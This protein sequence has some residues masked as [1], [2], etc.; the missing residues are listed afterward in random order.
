MNA[1]TK[2]RITA[3]ACIG[4]SLGF[5]VCLGCS[6]FIDF[7][8]NPVLVESDPGPWACLGQAQAPEP[9][10]IESATVQVN[11]CSFVSNCTEAVVGLTAKVCNKRDVGCFDPIAEDIV[12]D[13]GLITVTVPTGN[14]GFDGYLQINSG[15][16][17]CTDESAFGPVGNSLC[18]MVP[19]CDPANPNESCQVPLFAPALLFMNPAITADLPEPLTLPLF[20]L[21]ALA[22]IVG[23][24]GV[25]LDPT[26][27]AVFITAVDCD[28]NPASGVTYS[29]DQSGGSVQQLYV[30]QGVVSDASQTDSSGIGGFV[31]VPPGFTVVKASN[32]EGERIGEIGLQAAPLTLSYSAIV[33]NN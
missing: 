25:Q 10:S 7:P 9:P 24:A 12:D 29:I 13:N 3:R 32:A 15:T 17:L 27:G 19:A 30:D 6:E 14:T 4:A 23:A 22:A 2:R 31:G 16:A 26:R 28:G 18:G 1:G 21:P 33:P 5:S 8:E 20:P 11:A